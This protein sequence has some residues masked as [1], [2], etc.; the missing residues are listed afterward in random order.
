KVRACSIRTCTMKFVATPPLHVT[1]H[2]SGKAGP[3]GWYDQRDALND[4]V[5]CSVLKPP[6]T[7]A[8]PC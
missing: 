6:Q 5:T 8:S 4:R 2:H 3:E 1:H 7:S